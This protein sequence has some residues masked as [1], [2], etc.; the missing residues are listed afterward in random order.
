MSPEQYPYPETDWAT[1]TMR[2]VGDPGPIEQTAMAAYETPLQPHEEAQFQQWKKKYAPND[3]GADYDLRG[4]FKAGLT[5]DPKTGHWPD[6]YKKPNHPTFSNE[7]IYA[8]DRPDLAGHWE[9][10]TYVHPSAAMGRGTPHG[11]L[12]RQQGDVRAIHQKPTGREHY[13]RPYPIGVRG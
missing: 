11:P 1:G 12:P 3:S 9:G 5:P 7:S 10:N 2:K 8:K 6:T 13:S 4:A